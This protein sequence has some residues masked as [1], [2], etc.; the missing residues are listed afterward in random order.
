MRNRDTIYVSNAPATG[1]QKF[2]NSVMPWTQS[3]FYASGV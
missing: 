1:L 2:I 3:A